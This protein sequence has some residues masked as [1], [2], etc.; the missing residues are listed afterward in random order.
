M[1]NLQ[2]I[3]STLLIGLYLAPISF[4]SKRYGIAAGIPLC[5]LQAGIAVLAYTCFDSGNNEK[6]FIAYERG[7]KSAIVEQ[8]RLD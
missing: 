8:N 1:N 2:L 5:L 4:I 7:R 3:S 6:T